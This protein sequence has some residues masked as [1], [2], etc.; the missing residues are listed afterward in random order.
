[1][2]VIGMDPRGRPRV[3]TEHEIRTRAP[4]DGGDRAARREPVVELAVDVAEEL[5]ARRAQHR[6]GGALLGLARLDQRVACRRWGPTCPWRRRCRCTGA[7]SRRRRP[8]SRAWRRIRTRCR[9]GARRSPARAPGRGGR[10]WSRCVGVVSRRARSSGMSTSKASAGSRTTRTSSSARVG[11]RDV[12]R[13]RARAVRELE[14]RVDGHG[15]HRRAVAAMVGHEHR[16]RSR[17]VAG[18]FV[19]RRRERQVAVHDDDTREATGAGPCRARCRPR[20][21]VIRD[22]PTA[23]AHGVSHHAATS[24]ALDTTTMSR[25]PAAATTASAMRCASATRAS[26]S[27]T[28]ARR[29]FPKRKDRRGTT[30]PAAVEVVYGASCCEGCLRMTCVCYRPWMPSIP[31]RRA[32]STPACATGCGGPSKAKTGSR[33]TGR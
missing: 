29:A 26:S 30:I 25:A 22:P 5:D 31:A 19:E 4:D 21:R 17:A 18:D 23:R 12:P 13:E 14:R 28:R 1:M 15:A 10:A 20:H 3:V 11:G 27:R 16:D 33:A 6:G 8:T 2:P 24:G 7:P 32:S 9:R